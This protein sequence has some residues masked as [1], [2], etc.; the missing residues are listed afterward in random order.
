MAAPWPNFEAARV[1][2]VEAYLL[3]QRAS[4]KKIS[5]RTALNNHASTRPKEHGGALVRAVTNCKEFAA[6]GAGWRCTLTLPN[7]FA[8]GDGRRLVAIGESETKNEASEFA[9]L[10]AVGSLVIDNPGQV[11]LRPVHWKVTP[12]V[13]VANL[14]GVAANPASGG[15]AL[16]VRT[17]ARLQGAGSEADAHDADARL[18]EL[19]EDILKTHGGEFD[20]PRI[21]QKK[22]RWRDER[23]W[24]TFNK[25]L[26]P[27]GL[28]GFLDKRSDN[29]ARRAHAGNKG[30]LI[31]WA[32]W[33][34]QEGRAPP[35]RERPAAGE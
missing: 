16:P 26:M 4:D 10:R 17:P 25:L 34:T 31:T 3:E 13:L 35:P 15:R 6:S 20:P 23:P 33:V 14:P 1:E 11:V 28:K 5:W 30:M 8:P 29:F 9:C 24:G 7:S 19:V 2:A 12:D 27:G 21:S 18:V 32:N 22:A